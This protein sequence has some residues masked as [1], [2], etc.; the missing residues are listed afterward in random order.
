M[1]S[2]DFNKGE[3]VIVQEVGGFATR[4]EVCATGMGGDSVRRLSLRFLDR[5]PPD[6]LLN[7]P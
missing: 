7:A 6:R 5:E 2:L 3:V 1:T 4:A